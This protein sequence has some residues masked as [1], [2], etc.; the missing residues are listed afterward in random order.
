M[1]EVGHGLISGVLTCNAYSTANINDNNH[2]QISY[3][4]LPA[5]LHLSRGVP[6]FSFLSLSSP[7]NDNNNFHSDLDR[8]SEP[9]KPLQE[10]QQQDARGRRPHQ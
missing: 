6:S 7:S 2:T 8:C 9:M 1:G 4:I 10:G 3:N 5:S